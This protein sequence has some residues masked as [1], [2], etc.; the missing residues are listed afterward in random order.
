MNLVQNQFWQ[1]FGDFDEGVSAIVYFTIS[2]K[3]DIV[4]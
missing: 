1:N 3:S 4:R 2:D